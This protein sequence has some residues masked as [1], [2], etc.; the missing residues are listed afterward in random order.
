HAPKKKAKKHKKATKSAASHHYCDGCDYQRYLAK[1]KKEKIAAAKRAAKKAAAEKAREKAAKLKK[2]KAKKHAKKE[3]EHR[4]A[5]HR[6]KKAGKSILGGED[7]ALVKI[8]G[9]GFAICRFIRGTP[10]NTCAVLG[11]AI[12]KGK[13]DGGGWYYVKWYV[14][15]RGSWT[16]YRV[17]EIWKKGGV[18]PRG[19][20][21]KV[22]GEFRAD[23]KALR[24]RP[25]S[26]GLGLWFLYEMLGGDTRSPHRNDPPKQK[27]KCV[28]SWKVW[29]H[30][31]FSIC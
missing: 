18:T 9:A 23:G 28:V 14:V 29:G 25:M 19:Q 15:A 11:S 21:G 4:K 24:S 10:A 2:K 7:Y 16:L 22:K 3:K 12:A 30:N 1:K 17:G 27:T 26:R 6:P 5:K 13:A 8:A 20:L 31:V